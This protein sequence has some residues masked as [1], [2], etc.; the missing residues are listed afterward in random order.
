MK[1]LLM[2]VLVWTVFYCGYYGGKQETNA[3]WESAVD[4]VK[5]NGQYAPTFITL[6]NGEYILLKYV[7]P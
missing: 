1:Y 2:I 3:K 6:P 7:K 5:V 4:S